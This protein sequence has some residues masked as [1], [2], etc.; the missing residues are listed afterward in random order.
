[1]KPVALQ[2]RAQ[3]F[4]YVLGTCWTICRDALAKKELGNK[5]VR[6]RKSDFESLVALV[7][8]L[9][10]SI[11]KLSGCNTVWRRMDI[12]GFGDRKEFSDKRLDGKKEP[13][14]K[15]IVQQREGLW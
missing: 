13:D 11:P 9:S 3:Q 1:V 10:D 6:V 8:A 2:V 14:D 5:K 15:I 7:N 12:A 4:G